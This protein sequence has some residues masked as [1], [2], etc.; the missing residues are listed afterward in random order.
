MLMLE[1]YVITEYNFMNGLVDQRNAN[2]EWI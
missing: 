2:F 1:G